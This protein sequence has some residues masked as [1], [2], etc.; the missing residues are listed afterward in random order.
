MNLSDKLIP[1]YAI[2]LKLHTTVE[3]KLEMFTC[4]HV[5]LVEMLLIK[6]I[7]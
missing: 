6:F 2:V 3:L 4:F 1:E 5:L 7:L